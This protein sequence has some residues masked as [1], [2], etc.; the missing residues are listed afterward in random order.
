MA[1]LVMIDA[2]TLSTS[3]E[4]LRATRVGAD[5]EVELGRTPSGHCLLVV[6]H[7]QVVYVADDAEDSRMIR[8]FEVAQ[9]SRHTRVYYITTELAQ[10]SRAD[11]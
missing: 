2:D 9:A 5:L 6:D 8:G 11:R 10:R 7:A 1:Y 4:V 3:S